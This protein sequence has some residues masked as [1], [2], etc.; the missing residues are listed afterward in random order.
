MTAEP[1]TTPAARP[2]A[3]WRTISLASACI[4]I[5][6]CPHST[7][8][9]AAAGPYLA[10]TQDVRGGV[11]R[12]DEAARVSPETYRERVARAVPSPGD[13]LYSR[14]GTYF[15]VAAEVPDGIEVCLGQRMVL[16]RPDPSVVDTRFLRYWLNSPLLAAHVQAHRDGSVAERLNLPTIRALPVAVPPLLA[17]RRIADILGALDDKIEIN[18]RVGETL[19]T[20]ARAMFR[21]RFV[22]FEAYPDAEL[23]A[24]EIGM[25]P[26]G[27]GASRL[28]EVAETLLGGTPSRVENRFWGGDIP[29]LNSG[30]ANEF[31]VMKP[32]E[33]ITRSGLEG[34]ATKLVPAR[35]TLIAITGETLGQIT[36]TEIAACINQSLVAIIGS[37][38]LP[39]EFL[40]FWLKE[41]VGDLLAAQ[42]GAAQQHVNKNDVNRLWVLRPPAT[43][44]GDYVRAVRPL[45]DRIALACRES[46]ALGSAR[47]QLLP[48]LM[49]GEV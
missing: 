2:S 7:P 27:W 12:I 44:M 4:G 1:A 35:T 42:T 26:A 39:T 24:S 32:T 31:R 9:L 19:E 43:V 20:L 45:F 13:I 3:E 25:I 16:I 8:D 30:T 47:D 40:Y 48:R 49:R 28:G 38:A 14:E 21:S 23:T 29:W 11:F 10:R 33:C 22:T 41:R 37:E 15:G 36:V 5:F 18:R 34:S 17:Q 6:D 46:L